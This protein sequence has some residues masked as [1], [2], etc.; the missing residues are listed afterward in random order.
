M[1]EKWCVYLLFCD[2]KTFY[3][4]ITNNLVNRY[5]EHRSKESFFTKKFSDHTLV[6]CEEYPDRYSAADRE[7]QLKGW[8]SV[9]KQKLVDKK[10]GINDCTEF[11]KALLAGESHVS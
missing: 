7:G 11:A 6:Y 3:V 2:Q 10:L 8:S 1:I 4:G 5:R 9:K